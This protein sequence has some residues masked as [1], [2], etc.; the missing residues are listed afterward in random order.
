GAAVPR[1]GDV[2]GW[3]SRTIRPGETE[4]PALDRLV[5]HRPLVGPGE[6]ARARHTPLESRVEL[7]IEHARLTEL[8]GGT[9]LGVEA[10][11]TEHERPVTGEVLQ[12]GQVA[13]EVRLPFEEHV[14]GEEVERVERE[15]LGGRV[16][17]VGDELVGILGPH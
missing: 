11:L 6:D 15:V 12:P 4:A 14:E 7:P 9:L 13:T 16:V 5:A 8:A 17:R 2:E 1:A 10:N 3:A